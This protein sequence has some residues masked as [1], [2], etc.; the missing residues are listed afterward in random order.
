[1]HLFVYLYILYYERISKALGY[2]LC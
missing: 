1:M 2:G